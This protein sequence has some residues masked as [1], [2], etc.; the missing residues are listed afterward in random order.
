MVTCLAATRRAASSRKLH[1]SRLILSALVALTISGFF[2]AADEGGT[3]G[4]PRPH[5]EIPRVPRAPT[6]EDFLLMRPPAD[7]EGALAHAGGFIQQEP[8]DGE[9]ST[10]H[11]DV[12]LGY[13]DHHLYVI[14]VAFD[15]EPD[16]LRAH[17][18][19]RENVF[20]DDTV[21]VQLDTFLDQRRAYSFLVNPYGVQWDAIFTERG[22][23]NS[24]F[25]PSWD[26]VW[27]S[28]GQIT[29]RGY[30]VWMA[31]PFKSLRFPPAEQQTWG[32]VFNREIP[33]NNENTFWPRVSSR[34]EGRLN[35]EATLGG[36][37]GIS[38]GRNIQLI[39][40]ATSRRF[41]ALD[42]DAVSFVRDGLEPDAGLD[43]KLV[44]QDSLALDLT[45]NPDFSQVESDLPQ[46]TVNERFE[47]Q[48]PEKRP[49]F[50]ENADFFRTPVELLFTRRVADPS[51]GART[52]GKIGKYSV[53][54]LLVDDEAPGDR[55]WLGVVRVARDIL[56]QSKIGLLYTDRRLGDAYNRVGGIDGRIKLNDNWIS[57]FQAA[58]ASTRTID[59]ER[60]DDHLYDLYFNR[61]GRKFTSH[62]H[63]QDIGRDFVTETGFVP[64]NDVREVHSNQSYRFRPEGET[65]VAWGPEITAGQISDHEGTRLDWWVYSAVRWEWQRQT[66]LRVYGQMGEER[67]RPEDLIEIVVP[68]DP[69]APPVFVR[70][71][72]FDTREVGFSFDTRFVDAVGLSLALET[73]R[74]INLVPPPDQPPSAADEN[75]GSV[76]LT[77][78]PGTRARIETR[79]LFTRLA[80]RATDRRIL[81]NQIIRTRFDWQFDPRLSLRT[82]LQYERT[83]TE[84][85]LTRLET[86]KNL[87]V[88]LLLTYLVNPWTALYV[89][90]NTN[91]Q[92]LELVRDPMGDRLVRTDDDFLNDG[93]Q[94]FVKFSYLFR[95]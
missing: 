13:D 5:L 83:A 79:Y 30:V 14:F 78:R 58:H 81:S 35:Q 89:G 91:H 84:P 8:S 67:L 26:T 56:R 29:D 66:D 31:L 68:S 70:S 46:I 3:L 9:P 2:A 17:I 33:R 62:N 44:F 11:T 57:S 51:A 16:K 34:I 93:R 49:F 95:L 65:L 23:G 19:R 6:L 40:Y 64:R 59:G 69:A 54:A 20:G 85:T 82:I 73:G 48:F 45:V 52:T 90:Y 37:G 36:L 88:D 80:D 77:L 76:E 25:D 87:N 39:P 7:L 32:V 53:G 41:R 63:Y 42:E 71:L 55:A 22:G 74:A 86:T 27:Q 47:V 24:N 15:D 21:E 75:R 94:V 43:A 1:P 50:L 72:D 61:S 92:N 10:Q 4:N 60:L 18:S 38:P 28:R 12:Y